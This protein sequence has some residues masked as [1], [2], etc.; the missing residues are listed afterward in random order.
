MLGGR[1]GAGDGLRALAALSVVVFH[2]AVMTAPSAETGTLGP[3]WQLVGHLDLGLYVFFVLSGYLLTR[4]FAAALV[5][6]GPL[7]GASRYVG[8]RLRRIVP[9]FWAALLLTLVLE[10]ANG[11]GPA[12][13]ARTFLFAGTWPGG[14]AF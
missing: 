9:A 11:S 10:G 13:V 4:G 1:F 14:N 2:A 5:M 3:G 8:H 6:G 12:D 7:P